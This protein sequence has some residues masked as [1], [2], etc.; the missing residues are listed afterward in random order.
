M[1]VK[2]VS[3]TFLF[4]ESPSVVEDDSLDA[5]MAGIKSGKTMDKT[6]RAKLKLQ[7]IE[8]R[9]EQSRL[10]RLVNIAKPTS[11]PALKK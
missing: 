6:W 9:K 5:F 11:M 1:F 3:V 8:L 10:V 2:L 7:L 4:S